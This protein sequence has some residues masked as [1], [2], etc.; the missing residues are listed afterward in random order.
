[1]TF[2]VPKLLPAP[3][4]FPKFNPAHMQ[5]CKLQYAFDVDQT[6]GETP[7]RGWANANPLARSTKEM[8][9][10]FDDWN[11]EKII[12]L[13]YMMRRNAKAVVH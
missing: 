6:D 1:M 10:Q 12:A 8:G 3:F 7:E 11:H 5:T 4:F 2:L 13:A 9:H